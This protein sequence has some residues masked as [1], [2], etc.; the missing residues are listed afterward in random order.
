MSVEVEASQ[1]P[2]LKRTVKEVEDAPVNTQKK[3]SFVESL[4]D[5]EETAIE[6]EGGLKGIKGDQ[7]WERPELPSNWQSESISFQQIDAE[8]SLRSSEVRTT[9]GNI[10]KMKP[11][12]RLFGIT[13]NGN[14]VMCDIINFEHY[15]YV[16]APRGFKKDNVEKLINYIENHVGTNSVSKIEIT[17]KMSL[18]KYLGDVKVP[19]LKIVMK[20]PNL[21]SKVRT[22]F[23]K[24]DVRVD[25]LEFSSLTYDNISYM[26]RCTIDT[27]IV[28]MSWVTLPKD[29]YKVIPNHQRESKCQI[30][31]EVDAQDL[32][33]HQP[34]GEWLK[35]APLR[36]MS[37]DIECSGRK[38]IFP[39]PQ[40]D[41]V[42]QVACVVQI[43]GATQPFVRC[44]FTLG[45][46][47]P[48][49]GCK[50]FEYETEKDM[51][52]GWSNF[53]N[54]VDP[55][56]MIGYN[57][58]NFDFPYLI[59]RAEKLGAT[60]SFA[61]FGRLKYVQQVLTNSTFSSKAYGT[62]E[63]KVTNIEGRLQ[64]DMLQYIRREHKL[65]SY[66]LNAVSARFLGEQKE[67]VHHSIIS[68]LFNGDADSR[69]RLA[70]YCL[71]DA[72]L[73]LR[74]L[75]K[76][77][78]FV[79][80]TEMAR[81]TGVPLGYLL[82]RGQQIKVISQLFRKALEVD[83]LVPNMHHEGNNDE[84]YEGATVIEPHRGYYST[85]IA[86]LDFSSLYPSIMM[87]HNL[88]YT[89]LI[90]RAQIDAYNLKEGEDYV[91]TPNKDCFVTSKK[92]HGLLPIILQELLGARKRAKSD[93]KNESDPFKRAVLDGR[94][95]ALKVSANSVY[96]FTGATVGKLPCLAISSSVTGYGRQMIE[97][98]QQL[99][100]KHY[101]KAN[102][103]KTD[104]QVIYGD[105]DSVMVNFGVET[106]EEAMAL[107]TEAADFVSSTFPNPI[108]LE[109][110]KVYFPYLLINKKRYAGL[111]W[112]NPV[113]HDKMD[114]KGIETVRRDNCQLVQ[115]VIETV[116]NR[117]LI[118]RNVESAV[119]FVKNTIS[120][121]LQNRIDV[122]QLI[123]S[124]QLSRAD[125]SGKQA[126]VELAERMRKRDAGSAPALGDR[127]PY[128]IIQGGSATKNYD[129]SEDPVYVVENNIPIDTKYYLENQLS[130]P[131]LRIFA[132]VLG[133]KEANSLLN[134]EH[135]LAVRRA[136]PT[137][138]SLMKFGNIQLK[139]VQTCKGCR[140][141]LE[142]PFDQGAVCGNCLTR[143][144]ELLSK[145]LE[146]ISELQTK[147]GQL[148]T[149]CQSC[150]HS[151]QHDV[152]C[153]AKDCPIFFM[154]RRVQKDIDHG[155]EDI[156]RFNN[157]W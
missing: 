66:T 86:T 98:T 59:D 105:T 89:T 47:S 151:I 127:V 140:R 83:M 31:V 50:V 49:V 84:Q 121:L 138:S 124:K 117:I 36:I 63:N 43:Q 139:K 8:E 141:K 157:S 64:I 46:C 156:K 67:D 97:A 81:V 69:Y 62:S 12:V 143:V 110:E 41:P 58:T 94:Q 34:D 68:D 16:P 20:Q 93:L 130:K 19:F 17:Q 51:L 109:F 15:F 106:L 85:P 42:I 37:F 14:S 52:I 145:A 5:D 128:V 54:A 150:Q 131:L 154:R 60:K 1:I 65:R 30:E 78:T 126:H 71:K 146:D 155:L 113:K 88:C 72:F 108:K 48:I 111:Y 55:D 132:P 57:T 28:G 29:K 23:E 82:T 9:D 112:T 22:L 122:S 10:N 61:Y 70:V 116:L 27:G 56:V 118:D 96:G 11:I 148:W 120:E 13:D 100:Q 25:N 114:T 101:T 53:V 90:D 119:K 95:L 137:S 45:T 87:A 134:G 149:Q 39:D 123:I 152:E 135:T 80:M 115:N 103:Y 133:D 26:L 144:P 3:R 76:L 7:I 32:E 92:R 73:P 91:V 107:G 75:D 129:R 125:Y 147:Y 99:V 136:A 4:K 38:G 24:S 35:S 40:I 79:N 6:R 2:N 153:M 102:G 77:M 44:V 21:V 104:C 142:K 18:W 33:A 74:L